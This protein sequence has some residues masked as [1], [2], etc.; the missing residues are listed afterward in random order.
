MFLTRLSKWRRQSALRQTAGLLAVFVLITTLAWTATFWLVAREMDRLTEARL[1]A[2]ADKVA[3]ALNVKSP[4]PAPAF[5]QIQHVFD[6][7][8]TEAPLGFFLEE[9]LDENDGLHR[10]RRIEQSFPEFTFLLRTVGEQRIL[11]AEDT[12]RLEEVRELMAN[13]LQVALAASILASLLFGAVIARRAQRRL[14]V[15]ATG[16]NRVAAGQL[17]ARIALTGGEDDLTVLADQINQT[18]ERLAQNIE[19]MRVQ[20]SNLAHDLRTPLARLRSQLEQALSDLQMRQQPITPEVMEAALDQVD[21]IVG[22]FDALL[23]IARIESGARKA[24]FKPID[25]GALGAQVAEVF[26]PVVEDAGQKLVLQVTNPATVAADQEL[27]VQLLANLIQNA[28]RY[29]AAGQTIQLTVTNGTLS[30]TDEGPGI[31]IAERQK[32][33][34]PLYQIEAT[35]QGAGFG[36]GLSMVRAIAALHQAEFAL[37]EGSEGQGLRAELRFE[38]VG[39]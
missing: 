34:E 2:Q 13:G 23:R 5:G 27:L 19:Q 37:L 35:R 1:N 16:L 12:E 33:L 11:V 26:G 6:R 8:R 3:A 15:V 20:S 7:S 22:T 17:D 32:V 29:G 10:L 4:L 21:Q 38:T 24:G 31:P 9:D 30:V 39:S 14:N 28:L 18:T 36:L 25:L